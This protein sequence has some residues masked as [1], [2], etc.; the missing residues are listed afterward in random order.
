MTNQVILVGAVSSI[1]NKV[2]SVNGVSV[3][4]N[5]HISVQAGDYAVVRGSFN[6][7]YVD[8]KSVE[9]LAYKDEYNDIFIE[10]VIEYKPLYI[11]TVR[12]ETTHFILRVGSDCIH[13]VS[14]GRVARYVKDLAVGERLRVSGKINGGTVSVRLI[15]Q[16]TVIA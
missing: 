5:G 15:E 2:I 8:A 7:L 6:N 1:D 12:R 13:C 16:R 10:G 9:K 14:Y 3:I 4:Y 11:K